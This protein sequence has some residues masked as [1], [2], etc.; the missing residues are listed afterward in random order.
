MTVDESDADKVPFD[1][2]AQRPENQGVCE[3]LRTADQRRGWDS[4]CP[5]FATIFLAGEMRRNQLEVSGLPPSGWSGLF[6]V[7]WC[8]LALCSAQFQHKTRIEKTP[9]YYRLSLWG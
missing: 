6:A 3:P 1:R 8:Y 7:V 9:P 4:I 2:N 5:V